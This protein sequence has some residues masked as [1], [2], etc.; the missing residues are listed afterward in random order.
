MLAS[1]LTY[2]KRYN[3][4]GDEL[5]SRTVT[6]DKTWVAYVTPESKQQSV[7][8]RHSTLPKKVK[9]SGYP[10]RRQISLRK[11]FTSWLYGM[12]CLNLMKIMLKNSL[13]YRLSFTFVT[14]SHLVY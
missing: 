13:R 12:T 5:L 8:W 10:V 1:S 6:G 11:G 4:E 9:C 14:K 2:L 7:E 3:R